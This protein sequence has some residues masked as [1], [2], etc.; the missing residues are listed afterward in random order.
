MDIKYGVSSNLTLEL[1]G[2]TDFSQV[3]ADDQQ[4]NLTR[5]DLYFPEKREFFLENSSLFNIGHPED[6][7]VFFSR[8]I[9]I[10]ED[11]EEIPLLGGAKLAGKI[12]NF[13]LGFI[14]LQSRTKGETPA[15]NFTVFR[16]T[17]DVLDKSTIG[18]MMTNRQSKISNDFN[19]VFCMDGSF[20]FG[21]SFF[22][23]SYFAM[24]DSPELKGKNK[25]AKLG[26]RWISDLWEFQGNHINIQDNFN[27]EMGFFPRT[28]I[29][30]TVAYAGYTP[31]PK[32]PGIR[33]LNPHIRYEFINSQG[34]DFLLSKLHLD[35]ALD[36]VNGGRISLQW[37]KEKEHVDT[38]FNIHEDITLPVATYDSPWWEMNIQSD[39]SRRIWINPKYRWGGFYGGRGRILELNAGLRPFSSFSTDISFIN[40][41]I[42]LTQGGFVNRLL[43]ARLI[44]SYSPQL[45]LIG[46]L[47]WNSNTGEV[48]INVRLNFIHRPGSDLFLVF[49]ERRQIE[50][51][52][53]GVK[54]RSIALKFTYLFNL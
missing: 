35:F 40:Q 2:N 3:E 42:D 11:G 38:P 31:Q 53:K 18:F 10:S 6:G 37:N 36:L 5:F 45:A 8:R 51:E 43:R 30:K 9:G 21:E 46:L 15:N 24:T 25:A 27:A 1:T 12:G 4:I 17:R 50:R 28:G 26:F 47:Q 48:N 20:A 44:Y 32:I 34:G 14:N 23:N 49:N 41:D 33:R 52:S 39:K 22:M 54:D 7:M 13:D 16:L 19:R 29:Q